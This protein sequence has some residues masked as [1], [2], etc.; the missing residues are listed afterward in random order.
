MQGV[1]DLLVWTVAPR[2]VQIAALIAVGVGLA[3]L[4]VE[5]GAVRLIA[6]FSRPLTNPANLP[7]EV[8][9]AILATATSTT[10]GYGM[11]AEYRDAGL[12]DD[13]ATLVAIT[14]NTFFGFVQHVFTYYVPVLI[15]ILGTTVGVT[16]VGIRAGIALGITLLG[17]VGGALL[18]SERN[19]DPAATV[20]VDEP[21]TD[22][23]TRRDRL[24]TAGS[25]S[26][27]KTVEIVPRLAVVYSVVIVL[28]EYHESITAALGI[29]DVVAAGRTAIGAVT[30]VLG[31]P[32]ESVAVVA[33]VT[34]DLT[35]GAISLAPLI[36]DAFTAEQAVIALLFGS[37]LSFTVS[38]FK[39]S[40]PFQYGI[41]GAEFGTK[42]I[43][44]NTT[45]KLLFIALSIAVLLLL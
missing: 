20:D 45:L 29:G 34:V 21:D 1:A 30:G 27:E 14:I 23:R 16:Y 37:A 7:D 4:A 26:W 35:V 33:V 42:V 11:L 40:I 25:R 3:N 6:R 36:G 44:L 31:L 17:I 22:D 24:W 5:F 43:I 15:P 13:R 2:V 41:W 38:T 28:M 19:V 39:R 8:G 9:T 12:L 32:E 10:A 18:L